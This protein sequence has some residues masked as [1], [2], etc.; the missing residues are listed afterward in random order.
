MWRASTNCYTNPRLV[1][2]QLCRRLAAAAHCCTLLGFA[3]T[4]RVH[5]RAQNCIFAWLAGSSRAPERHIADPRGP[6]QLTFS[7]AQRMWQYVWAGAVAVAVLR[8]CSIAEY[9]S[10]RPRSCD[11]GTQGT[12]SSLKTKNHLTGR[13]PKASLARYLGN[14][15]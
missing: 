11:I 7:R 5:G 14:V 1:G 4:C 10:K 15:R 9:S 6:H 13:I 2:T 12:G 3:Q 8:K